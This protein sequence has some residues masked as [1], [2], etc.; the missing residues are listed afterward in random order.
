MLA[1][2][3]LMCSHFLFNLDG[4][5]HE[6]FGIEESQREV[7]LPTNRAPIYTGPDSTEVNM[8]WILHNFNFFHYHMVDEEAATLFDS[9]EALPLNQKLSAWQQPLQDGA[10]ALAKHWKGTYSYLDH[11]EI[12]KIRR[13][14]PDTT[15]DMYFIDKNIED[16]RIQVSRYQRPFEYIADSM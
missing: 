6:V 1:A 14:K 11:T 3:K 4:V 2:V 9:M 8:P 10:H 5:K 7:Y 12:R 13:L 15:G 16:G